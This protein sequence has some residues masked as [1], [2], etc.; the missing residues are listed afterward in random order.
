ME[1]KLRENS[2]KIVEKCGKIAGTNPPARKEPIT[3]K[4]NHGHTI[5]RWLNS[6]RPFLRGF[7]A[8]WVSQHHHPKASF[9]NV[10]TCPPGAV[11]DKSLNINLGDNLCWATVLKESGA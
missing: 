7:R 10:A 2:G 5:T 9:W 11:T 8:R 3:K 4:N 6:C 1:G